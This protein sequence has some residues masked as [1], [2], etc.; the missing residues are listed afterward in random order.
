MYTEDVYITGHVPVQSDVSVG[1]Q[2]GEGS[3]VF[4]LFQSCSSSLN[5]SRPKLRVGLAAFNLV[6][7]KKKK[8]ESEKNNNIMLG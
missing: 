5:C 1:L 3:C 6:S 2:S 4:Y 8:K 7:S